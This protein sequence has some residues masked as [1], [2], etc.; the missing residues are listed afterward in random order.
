MVKNGIHG[1]F[2]IVLEEEKNYFA[3][4]NYRRCYNEIYNQS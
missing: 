3:L 2:I 4:W 1:I